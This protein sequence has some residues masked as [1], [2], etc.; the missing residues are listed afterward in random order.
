VE[1]AVTS[2]CFASHG[3]G[4]AED[5]DVVDED[6]VDDDVD[7]DVV[8]DDGGSGELVDARLLGECGVDVPG[9]TTAAGV[10]P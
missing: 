8:D 7:A 4:A 6:V 1:T 5:E 10:D 3:C 9:A 2:R